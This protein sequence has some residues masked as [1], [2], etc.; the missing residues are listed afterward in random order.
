MKTLILSI[1]LL[2]LSAIACHTRSNGSSYAKG[3]GTDSAPFRAMHLP[4]GTHP[5]MLSIADANR[6]GNADILVANGGSGNVSVYLGDGK[7]GFS[8]P[9]GSPFPAGQNPTDITTGDFNGDG[10]LDIPIATHAVTLLPP[11]LVTPN[12]QFS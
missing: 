2:Q 4:V 12:T 8:Q 7:G 3:D 11:L 1:A 10:N 5:S 6:D 9:N